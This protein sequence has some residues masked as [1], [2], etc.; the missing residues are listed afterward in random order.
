MTHM[1]PSEDICPIGSFGNEAVKLLS[2]VRR[3]QRPLF[4]TNKGE[5]AGVLMDI[6]EYE[7]LLAL[8]GFRESVRASMAEAERGDVVSH[9]QIVKE[10]KGWIKQATKRNTRLNGR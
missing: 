6:A 10:S 9:E 2:K 3:N 4:L 7:R 8:A 1:L 5:A